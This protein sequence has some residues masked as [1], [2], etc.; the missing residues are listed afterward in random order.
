VTKKGVI[1]SDA[2][3]KLPKAYSLNDIL[4]N[5]RVDFDELE[6]SAQLDESFAQFRSDQNR[7]S[8][9]RNKEHA[10]NAAEGFLLYG[11]QLF[12]QL[13]SF[14]AQLAQGIFSG[15]RATVLSTANLS[16][17]LGAIGA[18]AQANI[19]SA[20][21]QMALPVV[22]E[23]LQHA[24]H[25]CHEHVAPGISIT[26]THSLG[27]EWSHDAWIDPSDALTAHP[28]E[29]MSANVADHLAG[30]DG[31]EHVLSHGMDSADALSSVGEHA[32]S[33]IHIPYITLIRSTYREYGLLQSG[34]TDLVSASKSVGIDAVSMGVGAKVGMVIGSLF[35]PG[36]GTAIGAGVGG[37]IGKLFGSEYKQKD[38][39]EVVAKYEACVQETGAKQRQLHT[40]LNQG[41]DKAK[42]K[43]QAALDAL[44]KK[45]LTACTKK[46]SEFTKWSE[47]QQTMT[48]DTATELLQIARQELA[49]AAENVSKELA[50]LSVWK[51]S[52]WPDLTS[53]SLKLAISNA[54]EAIGALTIK[55]TA[56]AELGHAETGRLLALLAKCGVAREYVSKYLE[57]A[58]AARIKKT[59][60]YQEALQLAQTE[61]LEERHK[62]VSRLDSLLKQMALEVKEALE[63][64]AN[65]LQRIGKK[66]TKEREKLGMA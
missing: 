33:S 6:S 43:E 20:V 27:T 1:E 10:L 8:S 66:V 13:H 16:A 7:T 61:V 57:K 47:G 36:L 55:Q 19:P 64:L 44:A 58:E 45:H 65:Q 51:R 3:S 9:E 35:A 59:T 28:M 26:D 41:F 34:K 2:A 25:W 22:N 38:L 31:V 42:T 62:S 63:P 37:F 53:E 60:A 15:L 4:R 39:K 24:E 18:L 54:Q 50:T 40:A 17:S 56:T 30:A 32:A 23:A 49:E 48:A 29:V 52:I 11:G 21:A 14:D 46:V 12:E 5:V